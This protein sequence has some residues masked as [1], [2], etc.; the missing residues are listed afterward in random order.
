MGLK[1]RSC[2]MGTTKG[3]PWRCSLGWVCTAECHKYD[4][5]FKRKRG[6]K[7]DRLDD[8]RTMG[9]VPDLPAELMNLFIEDSE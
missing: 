5:K 8:L 2:M 3:G 4:R 1:R 9:E 7:S 6:N